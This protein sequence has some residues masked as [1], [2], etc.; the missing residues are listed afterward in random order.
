MPRIPVRDFTLYNAD[1][2]FIEDEL[3]GF[4]P[5]GLV[6]GTRFDDTIFGV[7]RGVTRA[8]RS[9]PGVRAQLIG[10]NGLGGDDFIR[11]D[12]FYGVYIAG[13]SGSDVL[14]GGSSHDV[15]DVSGPTSTFSKNSMSP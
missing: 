7:P 1:Q 5:L 12:G 14:H 6:Q 9:I 15:I 11:G 4:D 3:N 13:G 10:I 2:E 8:S